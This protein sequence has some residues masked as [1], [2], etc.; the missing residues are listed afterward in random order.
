M[1][2]SAYSSSAVAS[3]AV[4]AQHLVAG[5]L[6]ELQEPIRGKHDGAVRQ[7]G[8]SND[9]VLLNALHS[10]GQVQR[11]AGKGL[12]GSHLLP[13]ASSLL[14]LLIIHHILQQGR[15]HFVSELP[16]LGSS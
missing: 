16:S 6:G 13:K 15:T 2:A 3:P 14:G 7:V 12:G 11:H 10:G 5:K 8:V 1:E 9:K 4:P